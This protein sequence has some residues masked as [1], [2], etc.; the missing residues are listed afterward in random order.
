MEILSIDILIV[1]LVFLRVYCKTGLRI[2]AMDGADSDEDQE[3]L[4]FVLQ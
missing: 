4:I 2:T 3:V 1:Q